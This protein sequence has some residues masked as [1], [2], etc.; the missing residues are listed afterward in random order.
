MSVHAEVL[1]MIAGGVGVHGFDVVCCSWEVGA[2]SDTAEKW[3]KNLE[4]G[5]S[6]KCFNRPLASSK[7]S[8]FQN[9][10]KYTIF[11]VKMT[12]TSHENEK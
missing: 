2:G 1:Q 6:L 9:E 4:M 12:F 10:A 7:N 5:W 11:L 8:H 3:D